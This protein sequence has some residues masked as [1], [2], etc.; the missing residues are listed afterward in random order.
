MKNIIIAITLMMMS[1]STLHAMKGPMNPNALKHAN[2][3][4][5]L[6]RIAVENAALLGIDAK[7]MKSLQEWMTANKPAMKN[8]IQKVMYEEKMLLEEALTTDTDTVKKAEVMLETRK[9]IIEMK[10]KCRAYL[11]SVLTKEQYAN[12]IQI[13]RSVQ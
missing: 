8:M 13:Y 2:P 11:R 3:M 4:P 1:F 7:Q 5:N 9:Q 12:V 6:M 10:T